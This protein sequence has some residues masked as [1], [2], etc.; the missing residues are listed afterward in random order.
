[1]GEVDRPR[2]GTVVPFLGVACNGRG[3]G[4]CEAEAADDTERAELAGKRCFEELLS[5]MLDKRL[6]RSPGIAGRKVI[7]ALTCRHR[8]IG[9]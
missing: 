5:G 4:W 9:R 6:K 7:S 8:L 1:M 2:A 3:G